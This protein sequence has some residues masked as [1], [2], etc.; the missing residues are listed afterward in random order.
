MRARVIIV[1]VLAASCAVAGALASDATQ[2]ARAAHDHLTALLRQEAAAVKEP[3]VGGRRLSSRAELYAKLAAR[4][5]ALEALLADGS[6]KALGLAVELAADLAALRDALPHGDPLDKAIDDAATAAGGGVEVEE[7]V[8]ASADVIVVG[9]PAVDTRAD[10]GRRLEGGTAE[11]G[12]AVHH[13]GGGGHVHHVLV[14]LKQ[15]HPANRVRPRRKRDAAAAGGGNGRARSLLMGH[16][17]HHGGGLTDADVDAL[18]ESGLHPLVTTPELR[19]NLRGAEG[20]PLSGFT[21][22]SLFVSDVTAAP[23]R[24]CADAPPLA[25]AEDGASPSPATGRQQQRR[26]G[27]RACRLGA[28]TVTVDADAQTGELV[29]SAWRAAVR[30]KVRRHHPR[31]DAA[32]GV[33]TGGSGGSGGGARG[34]GITPSKASGVRRVFMARVKWSDQADNNTAV[35]TEAAS[36]ALAGSL[37]Q[38]WREQSLNRLVPVVTPAHHCVYSGG[39]ASTAVGGTSYVAVLNTLPTSAANHPDPTCRFTLTNANYEHLIAM[40]PYS[41]SV[42]YAGLAYVPG[43]QSLYN[44]QYANLWGEWRQRGR[45]AAAEDVI[46]HR[47]LLLLTPRRSPPPHPPPRPIRAVVAH[48]AGHNW[49]LLHGW[50]SDPLNGVDEEYGDNTEVRA[51]GG[52]DAPWLYQLVV[53]SPLLATQLHSLPPPPPAGH[54]VRA[55]HVGR[56][57]VHA[58]REGR[59][60]VEPA[61]QRARLLAAGAVPLARLCAGGHGARQRHRQR[62]ARAERPDAGVRVGTRAH[63]GRAAVGLGVRHVAAGVQPGRHQRRAAAHGALR[64]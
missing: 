22:R 24:T 35:T 14:S 1:A 57:G 54:G 3:H 49:G 33:P 60:D 2:D 42:S 56:P 25:A 40:H 62:G 32:D 17:G 11:A 4:Q 20:V 30:A 6:D 55:R 37:T 31:H 61:R 19:R 7:W 38:L 63:D 64:L 39:V 46:A 9:G 47:V 28:S 12:G 50:I 8:D 13:G 41:G 48:E 26:R 15:R 34:L 29:K 18:A 44:G 51:L 43:W 16:G 45:G 53:F 52:A 36:R 59:A 10:L 58:G 23:A 5:A 21:Y 27:R